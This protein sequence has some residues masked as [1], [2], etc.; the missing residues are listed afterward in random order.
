MNVQA[1]QQVILQ[2]VCNFNRLR[3]ILLGEFGTGKTNFSLALVGGDFK[4]NLES[5]P[6]VTVSRTWLRG[7]LSDIQQLPC[8]P[9]FTALKENESLLATQTAHQLLQQEASEEQAPHGDMPGS[10][11]TDNPVS[12]FPPNPTTVAPQQSEVRFGKEQSSPKL[13]LVAPELSGLSP[14]LLKQISQAMRASIGEL[15]NATHV[16][17]WDCGGQMTMSA[18]QSVCMVPSQSLFAMVLNCNKDPREH[19]DRDVYRYKDRAL[20]SPPLFPKMTHLDYLR[21]WLSTLSLRQETTGSSEGSR[22]QPCTA[23]IIC[24]HID[25]VENVQ[26]TKR[27]YTQIIKEIVDDCKLRSAGGLVIRGPF[28][29]DNRSVDKSQCPD[30]EMMKVQ[31]CLA[32]LI[33][34]LQRE[35]VPLLRLKLEYV[36]R[37]LHTSS[38]VMASPEDRILPHITFE[39]FSNFAD[40]VSNSTMSEE[41]VCDALSYFHQHSVV[42]C[43]DHSDP[44]PDSIIFVSVEWLLLQFMELLSCPLVNNAEPSMFKATTKSDIEHLQRTGF[45]RPTLLQ[46]L[47]RGHSEKVQD[48]LAEAMCMLHL[49]CWRYQPSEESSSSSASDGC[50]M[51][52]V[53]FAIGKEPRSL[54]RCLAG[55][56]PLPPLMYVFKKCPLFPPPLFSRFAMLMVKRVCSRSEQDDVDVHFATLQYP[57]EQGAYVRVTWSPSGLVAELFPRKDE[58]TR[59]SA[60]VLCEDIDDCLASLRKEGY[61][62][63]KGERRFLCPSCHP[64][65]PSAVQSGQWWSEQDLQWLP[66]SKKAID[67]DQF[68]SSCGEFCSTIPQ[69]LYLWLNDH[70]KPSLDDSQ[71]QLELQQLPSACAT[72]N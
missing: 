38:G 52:Y 31:E 57:N 61:V 14:D 66:L 37:S 48:A 50:P 62:G 29:V 28:F 56:S 12:D 5:S 47:W 16:E 10:D 30:S 2:T 24:T 8:L 40:S 21:M 68:C 60:A 35:N 65:A 36:L 54:P 69:K 13:L 6:S 27:V 26:E 39:T 70:A 63:L 42:I 19:V 46:E 1:A 45:A 44:K 3:L 64:E 55:K 22:Q 4:P 20:Q 23:V 32:E 33:T 71:Q 49:A 51:L 59:H 58:R 67:G 25:V 7:L 34:K 18:H 9:L 17:V 72:G 53:P 11:T 43:R 41:D 15:A